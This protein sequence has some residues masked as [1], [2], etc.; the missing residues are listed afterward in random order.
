MQIPLEYAF[1]NVEPTEKIKALLHE[2]TNQL[3]KFHSGITS[4]RVHIRA[5]HQRQ[6]TGN[7]FEV[8]IE[9][10]IPGATLTVRA[11]QRDMGE[12]EHLDVA[13]RDAFAAMAKKL[14]R[15]KQT[16]RG[17]VKVHEGLLQGKVVELNHAQG[18]GQIAA[19][20]HRL[21]YFHKNSVTDGSFED[22]SPGDAVEMVVQI[23]ESEIGP[24]ASTVRPIRPLQFDPG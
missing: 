13:V 1:Q 2:K 22:L 19:T 17:D 24:Q 4:C 11:D 16:A 10:R 18:F 5:P 15:K 8:T 20:D 9:V 21:I 6:K 23:E 14:N 3:E 12:H 7:L